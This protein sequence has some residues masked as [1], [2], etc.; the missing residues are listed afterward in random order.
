MIRGQISRQTVMLVCGLIILVSIGIWL[1]GSYSKQI[2]QQND[3]YSDWPAD[4]YME[5]V[6][7]Q[8]PDYW[9]VLDRDEKGNPICVNR[10]GVPVVP[11]V[12][13]N[14]ETYDKC[15]DQDSTTQ[16]TFKTLVWPEN[17][18]VL[19]S[20]DRCKWVKNCGPSQGARASWLGIDQ[21]C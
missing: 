6:G 14:G 19:A 8:C 1:Y 2:E 18:D 13:K 5:T 17:P 4:Q 12:N 10:F 20:S 15:F 21:N 16:K 7:G 11:R 3:P 9:D